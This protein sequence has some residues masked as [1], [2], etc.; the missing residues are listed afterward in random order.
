VT[1]GLA[2]IVV[3]KQADQAVVRVG[4]PLRYTIVIENVGTALATDVQ[5]VDTIPAWLKLIDYR[6]SQG[7]VALASGTV[8]A[9]IGDLAPGARATLTIDTVVVSVGGTLANTAK[10]TT[11]TPGEN[12]T[13][14]TST[15]V[16]EPG[17]QPAAPTA[18]P[19]PQSAG[20]ALQAPPPEANSSLPHTA[21]GDAL[22]LPL[23]MALIGVVASVVAFMIRS[24]RPRL[25]GEEEV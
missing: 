22:P 14:N 1:T 7:T 2:D 6:V 16:V 17:G 10:G 3:I 11:T 18:T 20:L 5:V 13:N 25:L 23:I 12:P 8:V 21:I 9:Q 4:D 19:R 24:T 15:V